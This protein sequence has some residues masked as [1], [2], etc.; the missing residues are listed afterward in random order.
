MDN[1]TLIRNLYDN[2]YNKHDASKLSTYYADK[3]VYHDN[4]AKAN[5]LVDLHR[6]ID[7]YLAAFTNIKVVVNEQIAEGDMVS[8]RLTFSA[9]DTGGFLARPATNKKF[10]MN[11]MQMDRMRDGK[12]VET[13]MQADFTGM[14]QQIG[15][16]PRFD[17]K[18]TMHREQP[19]AK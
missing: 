3:C 1:K 6:V 17:T 14:L 18:P 16:I 10:D 9:K 7:G 15:T 2:V 11:M 8:T 4:F 5:G 12:I 13:W 19:T